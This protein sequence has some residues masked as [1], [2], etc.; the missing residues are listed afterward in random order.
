MAFLASEEYHIAKVALD[1]YLR[2]F[3]MLGQSMVIVTFPAFERFIAKIALNAFEWSRMSLVDAILV[4]ILAPRAG[5]CNIF[6][7]PRVDGAMNPQRPFIGKSSFAYVAFEF[8]LLV[9]L[10][11]S[12]EFRVVL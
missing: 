7:L 1:A 12:V 4:A 8:L 9:V 10:C 6:R 11:L 2:N 3:G 5:F